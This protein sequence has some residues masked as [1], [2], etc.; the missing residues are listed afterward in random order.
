MPQ[1][2]AQ[3]EVAMTLLCSAG[4]GLVR[5][6]MDRESVSRGMLLATLK[7]VH[8]ISDLAQSADWLRQMRADWI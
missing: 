8:P 5:G 3:V 6:G 2:P 7:L 1:N 4:E